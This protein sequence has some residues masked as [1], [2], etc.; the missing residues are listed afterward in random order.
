MNGTRTD[1]LLHEWDAVVSQAIRPATAP[2]PA[3]I[4][5]RSGGGFGLLPLAAGALALALAVAWL[6]GH[7]DRGVGNP[8]AS[9]SPDASISTAPTSPSASEPAPHDRHPDESTSAMGQ[10]F[11]VPVD[12]A[13]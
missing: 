5:R 10:K 12:R 8:G 4:R 1:R 11:L 13:L 9:A 3:T 2:R 7:E 6:G